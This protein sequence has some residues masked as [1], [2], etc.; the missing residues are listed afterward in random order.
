MLA[1]SEVYKVLMFNQNLSSPDPSSVNSV[2]SVKQ[3]RE[4]DNQFRER[5][6]KNVKEV[7][8]LWLEV[9]E[10]GSLKRLVQVL[11][12]LRMEDFNMTMHYDISEWALSVETNLVV[13]QRKKRKGIGCCL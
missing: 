4:E 2:V 1:E 12:I 6:I 7:Q 11:Q 10:E 3:Q 13:S 9:F 8:T 5:I